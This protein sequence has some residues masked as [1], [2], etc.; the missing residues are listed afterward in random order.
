ME[1]KQLDASGK[2]AERPAGGSA[3]A[4]RLLRWGRSGTGRGGEGPAGSSPE[5]GE[6]G[7]DERASSL[8]GVART[9]GRVVL[10]AFI[11]LVLVRGLGDVLSGAHQHA[12][13][14]QPAPAAAFPGDEARAFA[15]GFARVYVESPSA[16]A[17][18]PYLAP[19]LADQLG[20]RTA[21]SRP[22][23]AQASPAGERVLGPEQALI[24]VACQLADETHRVMYIAVP[25]AR[26][27]SGGLAVFGLPS[28]V[29]EPPAGRVDPE[30]GQPLA[31]G[32]TAEVRRLA[33]RFLAA[34][35]AGTEGGDL[36]Y[37]IAPGT[38]I[39]PVDGGLRLVEVREVG[40]L[41]EGTGDQRTV[42]AQARVRD[43]AAGVTYPVAYRLE[44][45]RRDRWYV[46]DVQGALR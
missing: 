23:V 44:V 40:Q 39:A 41:G 35:L 7:T 18:R 3:P 9:A 14:P 24:T 17:L 29:A 12:G 31:G 8:R 34:Y 27:P 11:G 15:A 33:E 25:V 16:Q 21:R 19:G 22:R 42:L 2:T 10:W 1:V 43:A 13:P 20:S 5:R 45:V 30:Q 32:E 36:A 46:S 26:D 28:L 38:A 6:H 4:R 37:L